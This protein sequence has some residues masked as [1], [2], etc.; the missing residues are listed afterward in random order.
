MTPQ[1]SEKKC[2]NTHEPQA[3]VDGWL[4]EQPDA[5]VTIVDG[6]NRIALYRSDSAKKDEKTLL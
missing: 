6:A 5:K 4:A 2:V 1:M 3:V